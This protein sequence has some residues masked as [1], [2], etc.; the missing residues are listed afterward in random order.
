MNAVILCHR[1]D[2]N[3]KTGVGFFGGEL[4]AIRASL[5]GFLSGRLPSEGVKLE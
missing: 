4:Q 1:G 3:D 2:L 5:K